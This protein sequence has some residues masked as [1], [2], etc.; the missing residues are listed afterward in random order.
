MALE[1]SRTGWALC[2]DPP[3]TG[4]QFHKRLLRSNDGGR[5]WQRVPSRLP[6]VGYIAGLA[7]ATEGTGLAWN[8]RAGLDLTVDGGRSWRLL[9]VIDQGLAGAG[10]DN[11]GAAQVLTPATCVLLDERCTG[12]HHT[13]DLRISSTG[14]RSWQLVHTWRIP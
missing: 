9:P 13:V 10:C 3:G 11:A 7:M 6:A 5:H 1:T 2:G 4:M 8:Q 12:D 14:G